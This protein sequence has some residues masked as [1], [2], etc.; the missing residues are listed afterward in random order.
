MKTC[1]KCNLEL[2]LSEFYVH[3]Q[4]GDGH[5]NKCKNCTRKDTAERVLRMSA[6]PEWV[7]AEL[8]RHRIKSRQYREAGNLMRP[9]AQTRRDSARKYNERFPEKTKAKQAVNNAIRD[10]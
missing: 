4:M 1:F 5:L 9:N 10:R 8:E 6:N 7:E 2:P 3:R